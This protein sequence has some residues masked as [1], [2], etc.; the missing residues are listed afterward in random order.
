[1]M[2]DPRNAAANARLAAF[3]GKGTVSGAWGAAKGTFHAVTHPFETLEAIGELRHPTRDQLQCLFGSKYHEFMNASPER[4]AEMIGEIIG[5]IEAG[6]V[7]EAGLAK[8]LAK[9]KNLGRHRLDQGV[10]TLPGIPKRVDKSWKEKIHGDAQTTK[11]PGH[12]F[13]TY[14]EAIAEAKNPDVVAV[15]MDHGYNRALGLDP[16]TISPNRRPDVLSIY[17]DGT[18]K[19]I[20]VQSATD[21]PAI[22]RVEI[23]HLINN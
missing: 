1:L 2:Y 3:Y 8:M 11:T 13:R 22:L 16:K 7:T 20:E 4:Q 17:R 10:E 6:I 21:T 14:R 19:R 5:G 15:H 23:R 12:R 18:I 9:L